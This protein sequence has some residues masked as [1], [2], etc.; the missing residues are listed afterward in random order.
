M[1]VPRKDESIASPPSTEDPTMVSN[2]SKYISH[3]YLESKPIDGAY[4]EPSF[5]RDA[6][7]YF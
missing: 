3:K 5:T 1:P 6:L 4:T 2:P 7:R